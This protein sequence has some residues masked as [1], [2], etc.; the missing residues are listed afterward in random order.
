MNTGYSARL[1]CERRG[2]S[3]AACECQCD[4]AAGPGRRAHTSARGPRCAAG[5]AGSRRSGRQPRPFDGGALLAP[6]RH[7]TASSRAGKHSGLAGAM[8]PLHPVSPMATGPA[9]L[10]PWEGSPRQV[11]AS[12]GNCRLPVAQGQQRDRTTAAAVPVTPSQPHWSLSATP[13]KVLC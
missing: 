3:L 5:S 13:F 4:F 2:P 9:F 12:Y 10:L 11:T 8:L 7:L 6:T 1:T